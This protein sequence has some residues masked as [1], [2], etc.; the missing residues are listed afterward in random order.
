[1][2]PSIVYKSPRALSP[3]EARYMSDL[4]ARIWSRSTDGFGYVH[5]FPARDRPLSARDR[6]RVLGL[7]GSN[8]LPCVMQSGPYGDL[9]FSVFNHSEFP[10]VP[11]GRVA[12]FHEDHFGRFGHV[13]GHVDWE[14]RFEEMAAITHSD[15]NREVLRFY[16]LPE[17]RPASYYAY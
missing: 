16:G 11:P 1:M 4:D 9:S 12:S 2:A 15:R 3:D 6:G 17:P 14:K 5:S 10:G 7:I 13:N 8:V